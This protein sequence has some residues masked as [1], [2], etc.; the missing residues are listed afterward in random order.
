MNTP[1]I[2]KDR[3]FYALIGGNL[4][5][6]AL[7]GVFGL[8]PVIGLLSKHTKEIGTVRAEIVSVEKKTADL[9]TLKQAYPQYEQTYATLIQGLPRTRDVAGYQTELEEL[10]KLTSNQLTTVDTSGGS[11]GAAAGAAPTTQ[12]PGDKPAGSP[13]ATVGGFPTIPVKVD[14]SGTYASV[15]DYVSRLETMARF[16]QVTGMDLK[17]STST[18]AV[19][20]TLDLQ[21]LYL[22]EGKS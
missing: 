16:T 13:G 15:L 17:G 11:G 19:K 6:L 3:K 7:I 14:I 9:R 18:G 21:T 4:V 20:A 1:H 2:P 5:I 8:R 22:P 10:A 12:K